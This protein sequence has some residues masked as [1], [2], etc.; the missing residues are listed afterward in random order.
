MATAANDVKETITWAGR[1]IVA[2]VIV[3][4]YNKV[5]SDHDKII[6]QGSVITSHG[7]RLDKLE[8]GG[9]QT[10]FLFPPCYAILP[11][12]LKVKEDEK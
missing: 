9:K 11:E 1:I 3:A 2:M 5:D 8:N 12:T 4:T 10:S 7:Q 6:E